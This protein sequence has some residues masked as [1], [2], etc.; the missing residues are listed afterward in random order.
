MRLYRRNFLKNFL[1]TL[2]LIPLIKANLF[3]QDKK[4]LK[5]KKNNNLIWY[6]NDDD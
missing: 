6:L 3:I 2:V 4:K 1:L 5:L